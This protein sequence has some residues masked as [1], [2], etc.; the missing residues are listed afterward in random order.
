M[1]TANDGQRFHAQIVEYCHKTPEHMKFCCSIN[2][3]EYEDIIS[4]NELM[5][6]YPEE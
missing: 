2:D 3:D 6:F 1:D 5:E 4:Y